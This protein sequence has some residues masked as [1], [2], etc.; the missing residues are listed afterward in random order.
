MW[1][2]I[3]ASCTGVLLTASTPQ[4]ARGR[5]LATV[6]FQDSNR[7][8]RVTV[9]V[10]E[11]HESFNLVDGGEV[12]PGEGALEL[13]VRFVGGRVFAQVQLSCCVVGMNG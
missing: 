10:R 1:L 4:W 7:Y 5:P 11:P 8:L 13:G 3:S 6:G 2:A 12:G 9:L